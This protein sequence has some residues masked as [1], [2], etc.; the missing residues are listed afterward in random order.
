MNCAIIYFYN[1]SKHC[2][3][4]DKDT[5][6]MKKII[7]IL[8]F[9][10]IVFISCQTESINQSETYN[11]SVAKT[12][13][14][15]SYGAATNQVF[16]LYLP[17]NRSELKTKAIILVHGGGWVKGDKSDMKY[18]IPILQEFLPN[19]AIANIN[20]RLATIG[21]YAFPMQIDDLNAV[22]NQLKNKKYGISN[23]IG[24]IGTSAGGHLSLLYS[25]SNN[26]NNSIKMVASIVGPTNLTDV[27][28]INNPLWLLTF[29][30]LTG[31]SY[32]KNPTYFQQLSP[33]YRATASS[34]PTI[35][36]YGNAD[37]LVPTTQGMDLKDKLNLLG[38]EHEFNLYNGGHGNWSAADL[39][40][41]QNKLINFI[42]MKL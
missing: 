5:T 17:A 39:L 38:V 1:I 40:D 20:Y 26:S 27:N 13:F 11:N 31:V 29:Q 30:Q 42:K 37:E 32:S 28:Y 34:P 9:V 4:T 22:V 25:Y 41:T 3:F 2:T 23:D 6:S 14:N 16:D 18:L 21:N 15:I 7:S 24:F 19:Y 8:I 33:L 36:F 12:E 35:L 10:Q